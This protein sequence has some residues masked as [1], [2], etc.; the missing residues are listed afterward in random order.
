MRIL[1]TGC[2]GYIGSQ[3]TKELCLRHD[4]TSI[5]RQDFDLTNAEETAKFFESKW[6]FDVVLHC[7]SAGVDNPKSE[8]WKL[9]DDNL[10][11]YYN[12]LENKDNFKKL[13]NFGTG[14]ETDN[15]LNQFPYG[16]GKGIIAKSIATTDN[17]YNIKLYGLF[18]ENELM[19][20]FI[21]ANVTRYIMKMPIVIY[22]NKLMDF[23]YMDD[24]IKVV[25]Y[26]INN[27]DLPK[28][29]NCCYENILSLKNIANNIIN[30]LSDYKVEIITEKNNRNGY[31]SDVPFPL[32]LLKKIEFVGLEQGI[33]N[34]YEKLKNEYKD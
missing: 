18:D 12:L 30:N 13:I 15:I 2:K 24:L 27:N 10:R 19:K 34:V 1:I 33:I 31:K 3:L 20:R 7:A 26:Y 14:A 16:M 28:E 32:E 25:D 5:S 4:V 8:N 23:F 21:K 22:D 6:I 9:L 11:M 29:I 17:F